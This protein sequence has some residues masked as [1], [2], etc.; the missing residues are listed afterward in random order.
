MTF[1]NEAYK[2]QKDDYILVWAAAG[3][4]GK[5]LVQLISQ[6][7]AHVIAVA[8]TPEKLKIAQDLG[9]EFL[10]NSTSDDIVEKVKE[11]TNGEGVAASFDSVGK[12]TFEISLN[13]IKK[14]RHFC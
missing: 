5:I 10:I 9:A 8:S 14:K 1:V 12:D 7:G 2:V 3:G 4:V 13:S 6:L 11:I